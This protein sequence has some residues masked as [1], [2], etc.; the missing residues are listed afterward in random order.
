M[1]GFIGLGYMGSRIARR[2]VDAGYPLGV[3]NRTMEKARPLAQR[4]AKVYDSP[5]RLAADADTVLSM[6]TDDATVAHVMLGP[7][8]VV[9]AARPGSTIIDLSSV[10]P[11]TSRRLASAA[12]ASRRSAGRRCLRKYAAGG[13]R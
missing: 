3:Y 1:L 2:L 5:R 8:G 10:H 13:G 6:L 4:G 11:D 9:A 7:D 12:T